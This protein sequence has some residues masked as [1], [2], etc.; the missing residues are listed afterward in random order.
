MR[1]A[2]IAAAAAILI[3]AAGPAN[4]QSWLNSPGSVGA[5]TVEVGR[6]KLTLPPGDWKLATEYNYLAPVSNSWL[7]W[8]SRVYYQ[9]EDGRISAVVL[10]SANA[11]RDPHIFVPVPPACTRKDVFFNESK[12]VLSGR[13][14]RWFDCMLMTQT[15]GFNVNDPLWGPAGMAMASAGG[16]P[17]PMIYADF[18]QSGGGGWDS[19]GVVVYFN[20]AVSGIASRST[21]EWHLKNA[22]SDRVAYLNKVAAWARAYLSVVAKSL[23]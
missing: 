7:S 13:T 20:P 9:I 4:A 8:V 1:R 23:E 16:L 12:Q 3:A 14:N 5:T 6:A 19:I 11:T 21:S 18:R 17:H 22:T 2:L 15:G 10:V